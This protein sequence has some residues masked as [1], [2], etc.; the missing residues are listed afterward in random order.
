MGMAE[1]RLSTL[2]NI[3]IDT[4]KTGKQTNKQKQTIPPPKKNRVSST[5]GQLQKV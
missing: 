3:K 5:M 4:S 1:E 2:E